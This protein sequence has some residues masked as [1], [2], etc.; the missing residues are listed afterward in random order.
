MGVGGLPPIPPADGTKGGVR[1]D[2]C[3]T[4]KSPNTDTI[5]MATRLASGCL[6]G[7]IQTEISIKIRN[8]VFPRNG[9]LTGP[10][11]YPQ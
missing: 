3:Q 9:K 5:N 4:A 2:I 11:Y 6:T 8:E 7:V 10:S 1:I